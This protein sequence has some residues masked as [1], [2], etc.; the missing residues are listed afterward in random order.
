[1]GILWKRMSNLLEKYAC[2]NGFGLSV[3]IAFEF[4]PLQRIQ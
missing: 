4:S 2:R 1:M 3:A